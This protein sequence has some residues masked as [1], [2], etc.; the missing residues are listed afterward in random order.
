VAIWVSYYRSSRLFLCAVFM[1]VISIQIIDL[2]G[3]FLRWYTDHH[4]RNEPFTLRINDWQ[5]ATGL[6]KHMV[7]YP[8]L[9]LGGVLPGCVMP[10][11][12]KDYYVPLAYQAY[13]LNVTFNSGYV[14]RINELK[15]REYCKQ[16]HH[17]V[18]E[19]NFESDTIYVIHSQYW[20][21]VRPH[22]SRLVCGQ[23]SGYITCVSSL[24]NDGFRDFLERHRFE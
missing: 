1:A 16:I 4:Q 9:I 13:R 24:R 23:V 14:S 22:T 12:E 6:Y 17:M 11:F 7:L 20:D 10:G 2:Q 18:Q 15:G 5:H 3:P 21:L 19:G 8:P